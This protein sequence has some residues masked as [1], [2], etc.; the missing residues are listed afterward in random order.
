MLRNHKEG[1]NKKAARAEKSKEVEAVGRLL[2]G[3]INKENEFSE[4][5]EQSS[6]EPKKIEIDKKSMEKQIIILI[7]IMLFL[8]LGFLVAFELLKPKPYFDYQGFA[9]YPTPLKGT[10]RIYYSIP[11]DFTIGMTDFRET[12]VMK[13]DP[14]LLE[15]ITVDVSGDYFGSRSDITV[16]FEP[17]AP[18]RIIESIF[19]IRRLARILGI[20]LGVAV[21]HET[22]NSMNNGLAVASCNE[23]LP[24]KRII[25]LSGNETQNKVYEDACTR[26]D[27][28][29]YDEL[30]KVTDALIWKWLLAIRKEG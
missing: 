3:N 18:S 19:E 17:E 4:K 29:D 2:S 26:I 9:V 11:V 24:E 7:G 21:T 23:S 12:M 27:A 15:N 25:Y 13:T 14:R 8:L 16:L 1:K 28:T 20:N 30:D 10:E 6:A 5:K 22:E